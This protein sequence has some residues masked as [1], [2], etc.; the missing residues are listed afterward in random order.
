MRE[1][2]RLAHRYLV[3]N[4]VFFHLVLRDRWRSS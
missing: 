2:R 4:I 3:G 1:P